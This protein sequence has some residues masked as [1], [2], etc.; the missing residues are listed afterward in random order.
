MLVD[1]NLHADLA[2]DLL[3]EALEGYL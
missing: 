2:P 1:G 3:D